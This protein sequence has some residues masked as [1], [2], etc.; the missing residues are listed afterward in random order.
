MLKWSVYTADL[1]H[2]TLVQ[3]HITAIRVALS[4]HSGQVQSRGVC[5]CLVRWT[6][7]SA[8]LHSDGH[9]QRTEK[10]WQLRM[11]M[12]AWF[13]CNNSIEIYLTSGSNLGTLENAN[14]EKDRTLTFKELAFAWRETENLYRKLKNHL[15]QFRC[16]FIYVQLERNVLE[17][18][19]WYSLN[20]RR[21]V[22][23]HHVLIYFST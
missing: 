23:F 12:T 11:S 16:K 7:L 13:P 15:I 1:S 10:R 3:G 22:D 17:H 6:E 19:E 21:C 4:W 9:P 20:D 8:Y 2:W 18:Q 5:K 14:E